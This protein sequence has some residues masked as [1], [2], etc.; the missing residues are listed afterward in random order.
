MK[1]QCVMTVSFLL[2]E[3]LSTASHVECTVG[4]VSKGNQIATGRDDR[5]QRFLCSLREILSQAEAARA[6]CA[7]ICHV[8]N[9][10]A[11]TEQR[12]VLVSGAVAAGHS[13]MAIV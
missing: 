6:I 7:E 9:N 4:I 11:P 2:A 5:G 1:I 8:R 13:D 12:C 3:A 10:G